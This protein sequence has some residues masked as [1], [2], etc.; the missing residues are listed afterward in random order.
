MKKA[1]PISILFVIILTTSGFSQV[2]FTEHI[3]DQDFSG[4]RFTTAIDVDDDGDLDIIGAAESGND[5][6]WWENTGGMEWIEHIIAADFTGVFSLY[7]IDLDGDG[8]L[9]VVGA[10]WIDSEVSW[11]ENDD[12]TWEEH[13]IDN[14]FWTS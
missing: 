9:D 4:A 10:A 12:D 6:S 2:E 3:L 11:F 13:I 7:P 5:I 8:D 14:T 1:I